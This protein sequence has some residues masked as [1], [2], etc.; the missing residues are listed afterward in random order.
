M[1]LRELENTENCRCYL[2]LSEGGHAPSLNIKIQ[3]HVTLFTDS[4]VLS[5]FTQ[6]HE[7]TPLESSPIKPSLNVT[8]FLQHFS[9]LLFSIL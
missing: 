3:I 6:I 4:V 7:V 5:S 2:L 9:T 8:F 1:S